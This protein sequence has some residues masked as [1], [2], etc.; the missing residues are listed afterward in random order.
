MITI[1]MPIYNGIEFINE[2]INSIKNQTFHKWELII[3]IN[4]HEQNSKVYNI[5]RRFENEDGNGKI[6]VYDFYLIKG[7][8][9]TLNEMLK[10]T[11]FD[12]I[13][14]L[15]VDD[16]WLPTKLESQIPHLQNYDV[17]GTHCKYFG[18]LNKSPNIPTG[19][20]T[21]FNFLSVNP[22]INSSSLIKK[23]LCHWNENGIEDYDLWLKLWRQGKKFYNV[24]TIQV[25]HR[26]HRDS[27]FN[28]K[29]NNLLVKN[30]IN[31]Y[32]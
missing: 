5:A 22:I 2:S 4:G 10:Y 7:K 17:I 24:G 1:L 13:A 28:S 27:A 30:I 6:R 12:W 23:N 20:I 19:D 25:M 18:D 26:I 11:H 31:K 8:S 32:K 29:G 21:N 3:G 9:N 15:D 16:I 14:L